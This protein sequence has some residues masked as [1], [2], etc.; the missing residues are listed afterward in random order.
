MTTLEQQIL[1]VFIY[2]IESLKK[3]YSKINSKWF[4]E[5]T[6]L[7][8][9]RV[10]FDY[11]IANLENGY[12]AF[13][14]AENFKSNVH[15]IEIA[16]EARKW[17]CEREL[18]TAIHQF[19]AKRLAIEAKTVVESLMNSG[20]IEKFS[21]SLSFVL[22]KAN[23]IVVKDEFSS[24]GESNEQ[25]IYELTEIQQKGNK[26]GIT[27]GFD[28]LDRI[29]GWIPGQMTTICARPGGGK[30]TLGLNF[31]L[32]ACSNGY[33]ILFVSTEM[34]ENDL[35]DRLLS[36]YSGVRLDN[37]R[38]HT[39]M[40]TQFDFDK[41]HEAEKHFNN[42]YVYYKPSLNLFDLERSVQ[43]FC[44]TH[45]IDLVVVDYLQNLEANGYTPVEKL[46]NI[47]KKIP[48]VAADNNVH[49]IALA[50]SNRESEKH[51]EFP[52]MSDIKGSSAIEQ[53]SDS[54]YMMH[55][56]ED[57]AEQCYWL[58]CVKSR[59]GQ[60]INVPVLFQKDTQRIVKDYEIGRV[61]SENKKGAAI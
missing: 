19:A 33:K 31:G 36:I 30:T 29:G 10:I 17:F 23:E 8:S 46:D 38:I 21:E 47:A 55:R 49:I 27:T 22:E 24:L 13:T 58:Y 4:Y 3:Y 34:K 61:L 6:G 39:N 50:Q 45:G 20:D 11:L 7:V 56:N 44:K 40:L 9:N 16:N 48:K 41:F 60:M 18:K 25:Y 53:A 54:I 14:V 57:E 42:F 12:D 52:K 32:H 26:V 43:S 37:I 35:R 1:G 2:D 28:N 15:I 51:K 5:N 59:F